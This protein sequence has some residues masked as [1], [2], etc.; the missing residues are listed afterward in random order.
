MELTSIERFLLESMQ[1]LDTIAQQE[2]QLRLNR[3][4]GILSERTGIPVEYLSLNTQTGA[5]SDTRL[6]DQGPTEIPLDIG[7]EYGPR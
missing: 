1:K 2:A 3:F 6:Q 5:I 4:L 7:G